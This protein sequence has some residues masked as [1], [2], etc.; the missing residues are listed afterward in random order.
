MVKLKEVEG[1]DEAELFGRYKVKLVKYHQK[2]A[3]ELGLFDD[4]VARYNLKEALKH[5]NEPNWYQYLIM[6]DDKAVGI[7][8]YQILKSEIDN[9][10]IIYISDIYIE[11][12]Y[13]NKGIGKQIIQNLKKSNKR[14]ELECWYDLPANGF[15][16]S[17]G[18]K[19]LKTVYML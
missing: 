6:F 13:R 4:K 14:I 5:I 18:M 8:E 11:Q 2:Y 16:K 12:D 1:S 9:G 10:D 19:K 15:Y 3:N 17:I 7:I